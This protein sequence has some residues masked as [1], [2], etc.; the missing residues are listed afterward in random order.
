MCLFFSPVFGLAKLAAVSRK[1]YGK[2]GNLCLFRHIPPLDEPFDVGT[3][4]TNIGDIA[5]AGD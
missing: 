3:R 5:P 4:R 1:E 2:R